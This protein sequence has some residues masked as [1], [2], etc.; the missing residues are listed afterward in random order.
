MQQYKI[1]C[2]YVA[3]RNEWT[4]KRITLS[5][6]FGSFITRGI[7]VQSGDDILKTND[8]ICKPCINV[9]QL[10]ENTIRDYE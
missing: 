8:N 10:C 6:Q 3:H 7:I 2:K 5:T 4:V 9:K 1:D